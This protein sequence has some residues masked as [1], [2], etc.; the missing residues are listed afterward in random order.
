[1]PV[2]E[3]YLHSSIGNEIAANGNITYLYI[4]GCIAAFILIIACINFMNLSTARSQKRAKEVGVRKVM[5]AEKSSLI[6]QFLG[7]SFMMCISALFVA[8]A[9]VV[10]ML[11]YFNHLTQKNI[12]LFDTP[13][14]L[15]WITGLTLITGLF[16]GLYPAFYLSAFKPVAVLKGK[17]TNNFSAV[18]LRK[19]LV[20]FQFT[21]SIC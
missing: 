9:I 11:P 18:I 15:F 19:R 1:Q 5:G 10:L 21:I 13:S 3:I 6:W 14:L 4:L 20:I 17:I 7:E 2:A 16:A 12:R 8:L